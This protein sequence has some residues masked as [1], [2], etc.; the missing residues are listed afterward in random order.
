LSG[1]CTAIHEPAGFSADAGMFCDPESL[2]AVLHRRQSCV[3]H[4]RRLRNYRD[5]ASVGRNSMD[6]TAS[7]RNEY[8]TATQKESLASSRRKSP[9]RMAHED[10]I[11]QILAA[12]MV[13]NEGK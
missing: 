8:R 6:R 10:V 12:E 7:I 1:H 4:R 2:V 9:A 11:L 13:K 5:F 3:P